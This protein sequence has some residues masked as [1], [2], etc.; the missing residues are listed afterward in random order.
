MARSAP[1]RLRRLFRIAFRIFKK[2]SFVVRG[3]AHAKEGVC[4]I[5]LARLV[6]RPPACPGHVKAIKGASGPAFLPGLTFYG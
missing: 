3:V 6:D 4:R 1:S 2:C 5:P